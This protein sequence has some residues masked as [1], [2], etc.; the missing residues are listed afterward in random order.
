VA[1]F[2]LAVTLLFNSAF[3]FGSEKKIPD[4]YRAVAL[5]NKVPAKLFFA[6]IL[7]ESRSA[8]K[9][10][11]GR[12]VLPWPWTVNYAGKPHF[13]QTRR[14]AFSFVQD[15]SSRGITKF[16]VGLGQVNWY[17]HR[18]RFGNNLWNAFDSRLNLSIAA[19]ILREQFEREECNSWVKAIG[20]YHRPGQRDS[21]KKIALQYALRVIKQW[22]KI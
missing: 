2:L 17:W 20:C 3:S 7:N 11:N 10:V 4:L 13:F 5:E 8:T 14:Q 1:V 12:R 16:D 15:L 19:R 6:L 22:E 9:N 21:D 18:K